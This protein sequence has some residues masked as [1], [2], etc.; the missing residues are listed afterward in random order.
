MKNLFPFHVFF[1]AM[2]FCLLGFPV[3]VH[4]GAVGISPP[5][6]TIESLPNTT[7]E[8]TFTIARGNPGANESMTVSVSEGDLKSAIVLKQGT[9]LALPLGVSSVSYPFTINTKGLEVGKTYQG[10]VN[11][12]MDANGTQKGTT[13]ILMGVSGRVIVKVVD[14]LSPPVTEKLVV[15]KPISFSA[16]NQNWFFDL[17]PFIFLSTSTMPVVSRLDGYFFHAS[18]D[19]SQSLVRLNDGSLQPLSGTWNFFEPASDQLFAFPSN[20]ATKKEYK[21]KFFLI[22]HAGITPLD[23]TTLPNKIDSVVENRPQTYALFSG[24]RPDSN[25][26]FVCLSELNI[27]N[28]PNCVFLDALVDQSIMSV[29]FSGEHTVLITTEN[30]SFIYD[31]WLKTLTTESSIRQVPTKNIPT[32]AGESIVAQNVLLLPKMKTFFGFTFKNGKFIFWGFGT[33][34]R[35]L[36]P[37][38]YLVSKIVEKKTELFLVNSSAWMKAPLVTL[39]GDDQLWWLKNGTFMTSP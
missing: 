4:A 22:E 21:Q 34:V 3:A 38:N 26:P 12:V 5:V 27:A 28:G 23:A 19:V 24:K 9:H 25:K 7:L 20:E 16:K 33:E 36:S 29:N 10:I 30:G 18:K 1:V 31:A 37:V 11:F 14:K 35:K 39:N 13:K 15:Q 8:K 6:L 32:S 17:F 2:F